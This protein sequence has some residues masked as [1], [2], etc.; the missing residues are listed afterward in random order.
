MNRRDFLN[1]VTLPSALFFSS[2]SESS[3]SKTNSPLFA[4]NNKVLTVASY[5]ELSKTSG[6]FFGQVIYLISYY[7]NVPGGGGG[8]FME[9]RD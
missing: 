2:I 9:G 8:L 3:V 7:R 5:D 6:E 1:K 4:P